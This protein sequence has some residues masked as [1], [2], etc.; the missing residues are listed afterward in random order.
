M[1]FELEPTN[2]NMTPSDELSTWRGLCQE[3]G[4]SE[5]QLR[6]LDAH[7]DAPEKIAADMTVFAGE[8]MEQLGEC[9]KGPLN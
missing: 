4:C 1:N 5:H 2:R 7:R 8:W 3:F 9:A 6:E